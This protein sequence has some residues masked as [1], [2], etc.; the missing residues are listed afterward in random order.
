MPGSVLLFRYPPI[1]L[2]NH[3]LC[4]ADD[5]SHHEVFQGYY[6][7]EDYGIP[8]TKRDIYIDHP[9]Y[10]QTVD[11][12]EKYDQ[13]SFD[14]DYPSLPLSTFFPA[15][16]RVLAR[17]QYWWNPA[18]PKAGAVS[19]AAEFADFTLGKPMGDCPDTWQ[20]YETS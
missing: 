19:S 18:H 14:P 10:N 6:Y 5:N 13:A 20:C 15:I 7:F 2:T 1:S 12:C 17:P 3:L 9:A 4:N 16:D 11:W 8:K